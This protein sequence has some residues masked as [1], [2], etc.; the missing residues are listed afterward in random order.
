MIFVF[1]LLYLFS[2]FFESLSLKILHIPS[3]TCFLK[4]PRF[5]E[6]ITKEIYRAIYKEGIDIQLPHA[7]PSLCQ[8]LMKKNNNTV[9]TCTPANCPISDPNICQKTYTIYRLIKM[10]LFLYRKYNP[11]TSELKNTSTSELKNT[12][13][14]ELKNTS[15]SELKNTSTSELKN[16]ST[17]ELKNTS[18]SELK[19]TSTSELKNTSTSELKKS[20][21]RINFYLHLRKYRPL[22]LRIKEHLHLRIKEHLHLRIKEHLH[23]RIKEHLHLKLKNTSM[24]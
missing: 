5:S 13:T 24:N 11:S 19:N 18:T 15:T 4:L 14:S 12:S 10:P 17:S 8:Y 9:T 20:T 3:S 21:C 6:V 23:L 7:R 22:H 1:M 2:S 16:T